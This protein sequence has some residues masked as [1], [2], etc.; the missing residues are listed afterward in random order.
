MEHSITDVESAFN[1]VDD[2]ITKT[3]PPLVNI[4]LFLEK[5]L[6]LCLEDG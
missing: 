6:K 4:F 3:E 2:V 1:Q 5:E